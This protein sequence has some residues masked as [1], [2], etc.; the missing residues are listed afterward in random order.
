V[1]LPNFLIIGA[2]KCGTD[3]LYAYLG[4]HPEVHMSAVKETNFFIVEGKELTYAGPGDREIL[5]EC[6]VNSRDEYESLF[7]D[8]HGAKA[9]GEASPWYI[10]DE[11]A[12]A[13]IQERIPDTRVIAILRHPV[14]RAFSAHSSLIRDD[15]ESVLDFE[16]AL[17]LENE[18]VARNWEPLWHLK[19]QGL[20]AA[21][22][23]RYYDRFDASQIKVVLYDDFA[24]KQG[25]VIAD[26]FA[27]LEVDP[28]FAPDTSRR[29]NVSLVPK[30]RLLH[31]V[32]GRPNA[33][34][35]LL[36]PLLPYQLR[37]RIKQPLVS[38][39]MTR[40]ALSPEVRA[41]VTEYFREDILELQELLHRDLSRWLKP[42]PASGSPSSGTTAYARA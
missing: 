22:L 40:P 19:R 15:R 42:A 27:F 21:Q 33:F 10:Y 36:K 18:R 37:Q 25:A 16:A 14:D 39:N 6:W 38:R 7:A 29:P 23:R 34:K 11:Y 30:N 4:Q 17:D 5:E 35:D 26:L 41:R 32:V 12:A 3:A 1:T 13:R 24:S 9:L 8:A 2:A 20:Y 28:G 31:A